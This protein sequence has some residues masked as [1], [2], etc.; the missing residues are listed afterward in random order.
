ML[1]PSPMELHMVQ[2]WYEHKKRCLT[3]QNRPCTAEHDKY[4][5]TTSCLQFEVLHFTTN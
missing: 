2:I 4:F 5:L 1:I 3:L